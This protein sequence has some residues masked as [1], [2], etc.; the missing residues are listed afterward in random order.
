MIKNKQTINKIANLAYN[1]S[2]LKSAPLIIVLCTKIYDKNKGGRNI[3]IKR[4][5]HL[6]ED[7]ENMNDELFAALNAEEHQ[8]NIA[9][10]HMV[11]SALEHGVYSTWLSYF[12]VAE[13]NELLNLPA[14]FIAS[15]MIAFGYPK[16]VPI[17][18]PKK[19]LKEIV[20][21]ES[22]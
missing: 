18:R 8:T 3:C 12:K 22:I 9:G 7:I 6:K 11:L 14:D 5:P 16:T 17:M 20:F 19:S 10:S 1:Q 2:W 15:E 13:L 21:Y 4:F